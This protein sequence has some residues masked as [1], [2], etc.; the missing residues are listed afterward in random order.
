MNT[1]YGVVTLGAG[2]SR[3]LDCRSTPTPGMERSSSTP[4]AP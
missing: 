2:T 1:H 4:S 3:T